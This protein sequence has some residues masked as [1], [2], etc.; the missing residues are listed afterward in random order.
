MT[1]ST[2]SFAG[3]PRRP[4]HLWSAAAAATLIL[5]SCRAA[6]PPAPMVMHPGPG[7][8]GPGPGVLDAAEMGL[9][10]HAPG[11]ACNCQHHGP[12]KPPGIAAPWP[13]G[14]Y[15]CDG[16]D[17]K[18][19]V[20]VSP[21]WE[22]FG[23]DPEDTIAH[24]DTL[25]GRTLVEPSNC[26]CLYAPRFGAVRSVR[27]VVSDQQID[28]PRG[29]A[30]PEKLVR[31]DE[32]LAPAA[33]LQNERAEGHSLARLPE[34][35]LR[36]RSGG[37]VSSARLPAKV[38]DAFKPY[39]ALHVIRTGIFDASQKAW[40][41]SSTQAAIAWSSQQA[42][43][44]VLEGQAAVPLTADDQAFETFTVED[45]RQ[46]KLRV[47][48]VASAC[49]AQPGDEIEFTLRFDNVGTQPIG[50]IVLIDNL[51]TRLEYIP[52]TAQS[53][54]RA[55]FSAAANEGESLVLRW[56]LEDA[57]EAGQGGIVRFRCRVR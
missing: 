3:H 19:G 1:R 28:A 53:S 13:P 54:V 34:A 41:A 45:R 44:V 11:I 7:V 56:E 30:R 4:W 25:D 46:P 33:D 52:D 48:K 16:G 57:L 27:R 37:L 23:L 42:V 51:T 31:Y 15:L 43:Q 5:C 35:L 21:E 10:G 39:E 24:Y 36:R 20:Q 55:S 40:L 49:A 29:A 8:D 26:V 6:A 38:Q 12:W 2:G 18:L 50:N 32:A 14:E 17:K 47:I 9:G 22:V